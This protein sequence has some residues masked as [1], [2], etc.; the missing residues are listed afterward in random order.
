MIDGVRQDV[1]ASPL[2]KTRTAAAAAAVLLN[3]IQRP[4]L[5]DALHVM[6]GPRTRPRAVTSSAVRR[7]DFYVFWLN[8]PIKH[9]FRQITAHWRN[10]I[11]TFCKLIVNFNVMR[12]INLRFT[13]LLTYL[14][15]IA[16]HESLVDLGGIRPCLPLPVM[17]SE[18]YSHIPL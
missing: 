2:V 12:S 10:V 18:Q 17:F 3:A 7:I 11:L 9:T 8:I 5:R 15:T 13:Y 4:H 1:A 14:L 16:V 6:T